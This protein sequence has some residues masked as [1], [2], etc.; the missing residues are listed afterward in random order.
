MAI[1]FGKMDTLKDEI[2]ELSAKITNIENENFDLKQQL[3]NRTDE[4]DIDSC[5]NISDFY[6][7]LVNYYYHGDF[8]LQEMFKRLGKEDVGLEYDEFVKNL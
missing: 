2:E 1:P 3:K 4:F 8:S 7:T 5:K 6:D